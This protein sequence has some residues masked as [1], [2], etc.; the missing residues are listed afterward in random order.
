[1]TTSILIL[2]GVAFLL[3]VHRAIEGLIVGGAENEEEGAR[4]K[5]MFEMGTYIFLL[6]SWLGGIVVTV[7]INDFRTRY[8]GIVLFATPFVLIGILFFSYMSFLV[9]RQNEKLTD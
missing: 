7:M 6:L 2:V 1:M 4:R 5:F 9:Y 8:M 3:L